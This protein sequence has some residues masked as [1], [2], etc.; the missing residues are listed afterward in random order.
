[1]NSLSSSSTPLT[2][3]PVLDESVLEKSVHDKPST[4]Q[5]KPRLLVMSKSPELGRVK[6]RMQP[7]LSQQESVQLHIHMVQYCLQQWSLSSALTID[8][9]V[10]GDLDLFQKSVLHPLKG[11]TAALLPMYPQPQGDLGQRMSSA[12]MSTFSPAFNPVFNKPNVTTVENTLEGRNTHSVNAVVLTGTDCPFI[13]TD[14][15]NHV[16]EA[17]DEYDVVIGPALDGGYVMLAMNQH[18]PELFEHIAWG[19]SE[20][21]RATMATI[22]QLG[23]RCYEMPPLS[24]IDLPSDLPLLRHLPP[25]NDRSFCDD[26]PF[27]QTLSNAIPS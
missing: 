9:W 12:V 17:M 10:G 13:S 25:L 1:M 11:Q 15:L 24:D 5:Q 27:F 3:K 2:D 14:Y 20:V 22:K 6:T 7:E 19:T 21:Y 18:Y 8:L 26:L 23:L 4:A 16:V